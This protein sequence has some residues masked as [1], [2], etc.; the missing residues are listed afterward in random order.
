MSAVQSIAGRPRLRIARLVQLLV[1]R[2]ERQRVAAVFLAA[3]EHTSSPSERI[4]Y[5]LDARLV[6]R[7]DPVPADVVTEQRQAALLRAIK[8]QGGHWKTGRTIRLYQSLGYGPV[9]KSRAA[10]DLRHWA[11]AGLLKRH[12]KKGVTYYTR[13]EQGDAR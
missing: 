1:A 12:D 4:A 3:R 13:R 6:L 10:Q 7:P 9:G 11:Q 8:E 5:A 2:Q